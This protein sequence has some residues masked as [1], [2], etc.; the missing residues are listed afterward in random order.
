[1]TFLEQL[2]SHKGGL[3]CLKTQLYWY[4]N[5]QW[6]EIP[7]RIGLIFDAAACVPALYYNIAV[8]RTFDAGPHGGHDGPDGARA[9]RIAK[10]V[11]A[12]LLIDGSPQWIWVAEGDV[13]LL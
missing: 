12:H 4:H 11:A 1:M 3:I 10:T 9:K 5:G 2:Q 13:E 6:D 8:A 7:D